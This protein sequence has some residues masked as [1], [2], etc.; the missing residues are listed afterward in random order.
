M[1]P[2]QIAAADDSSSGRLTSSSEMQ[3]RYC[4]FVSHWRTTDDSSMG[5]CCFR[6]K[7]SL[8]IVFHQSIRPCKLTFDN[9]ICWRFLDGGQI[10][11]SEVVPALFPPSNRGLKIHQLCHWH[12]EQSQRDQSR[13]QEQPGNKQN[14]NVMKC[15]HIM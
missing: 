3:L 8:W 10:I 4:V 2:F 5:S 13:W 11:N 7:H 12:Q 15:H 1:Y 9:P 14:D 6:W